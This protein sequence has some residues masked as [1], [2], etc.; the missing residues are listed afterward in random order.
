MIKNYEKT[1][2]ERAEQQWESSINMIKNEYLK[3]IPFL[4]GVMWMDSMMG[5]KDS[6]SLL[7]KSGHGIFLC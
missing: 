6:M 3:I 2:I 5:I 1:V 7:Y 4:N